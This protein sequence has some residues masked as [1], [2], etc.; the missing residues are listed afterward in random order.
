MMRALRAA[1][2]GVV[3]VSVAACGERTCAD[4]CISSTSVTFN[5]SCGPTDLTSVVLSGPC[6]TLDAGPGNYLVGSTGRSLEFTSPSP[7]L[8]HVVLTF[9]TGFTYSSDVTFAS[10]SAG[11]CPSY[12]APTQPTFTV[13]N[14]SA[15]C[16]DAGH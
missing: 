16:A 3:V 1:V 7:G 13:D 14:P 15:T 6:S 2:V 9:A 12:I 4:G 11:C 10:R 5:L 8:C